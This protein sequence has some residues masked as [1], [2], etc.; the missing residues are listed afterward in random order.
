MIVHHNLVR[1][2]TE[3]KAYY[4][5]GENMW[6]LR[7]SYPLLDKS[8]AKYL[9]HSSHINVDKSLDSCFPASLAYHGFF[10]MVKKYIFRIIPL[11]SI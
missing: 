7:N 9:S 4:S 6:E 11:D 5:Q 10:Y 8:N 3:K 1:K 2:A